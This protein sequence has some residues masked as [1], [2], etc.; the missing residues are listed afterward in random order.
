MPRTRLLVSV[1]V[2]LLILSLLCTTDAA[3]P[4]GL[5]VLSA[6]CASINIWASVPGNSSV[7][8]AESLTCG[9][10]SQRVLFNTTC[11]R[12]LRICHL[13]V[14]STPDRGHRR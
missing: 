12:G 6:Y 14:R 9:Q 13:I 1:S 8:I 2:L 10:Q 4:P 3:E 7:L 5:R 11:T